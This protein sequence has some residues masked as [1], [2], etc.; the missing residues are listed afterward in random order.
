MGVN[1][2]RHPPT[3]QFPV[4]RSRALAWLLALF[5]VGAAAGV[6]GWLLQA[7]GRQAPALHGLA[8]AGC[9]LLAAASAVHYWWRQPAA[10]LRWDGQFWVL[11]TASGTP[12]AAGPPATV[13]APVVLLDFQTHLWVHVQAEGRARTWLWLERSACPERWLDLRRAVYSRPRPGAGNADVT[14]LARSHGRE[15]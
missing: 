7:G 12:R 13:G 2:R 1:S 8:A 11:E 15:S 6:V 5:L 9:W 4:R 10:L 14:A 3:V